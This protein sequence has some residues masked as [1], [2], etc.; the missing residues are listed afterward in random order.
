MFKWF[1]LLCCKKYLPPLWFLLFVHLWHTYLFQI[2]KQN[3]IYHTD[4]HYRQMEKTWNPP[5]MATS[6]EFLQECIDNL[7]KKLQKNTDEQLWNCRSCLPQ[8]RSAFRILPLERDWAKTGLKVELSGKHVSCY[9][10]HKANRALH[11]L[12]ST[13]YPGGGSVMVWGW[14]GAS[15]PE[16]LSTT[17]GTKN[18]DLHQKILSSSTVGL[19]INTKHKTSQLLNG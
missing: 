13:V 3:L 11:K 14:F 19:C 4:R 10:W 7:S 12:E 9:L 16:W 17:D 1:N 8:M 15:G 18:S 2:V 5:S 6:T